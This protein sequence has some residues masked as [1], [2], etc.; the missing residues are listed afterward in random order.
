M[1]EREQKRQE[2]ERGFSYDSY[3]CIRGEVFP[4]LKDPS[5]T[6]RD[7]QI[8]FNY[9]CINSLEGV[10]YVNIWYS[11][12]LGRMVAE[13]C[14]KGDPDA[15]RWCST[16]NGVRKTRQM[17]CPIFTDDVFKNMNW[18]KNCRYK[19]LGYLIPYKGKLIYVFELA[20]HRIYEIR[21]KNKEGEKV[22]GDRKGYLPD[23]IMNSYALPADEHRK[24]AE[25]EDFDGFVS[26]GMIT[27][28]EKK[29]EDSE[30]PSV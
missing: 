10:E 28:G 17:R 20:S 12:M 30:S 5:V 14:N 21:H 23:D 1:S 13:P 8:S 25:I 3:K 29:C 6:I 15:V 4:N 27:E 16:K 7:G 11:E 19:I 2:L 24:K 18:D 26:Y 9:A 22:Q